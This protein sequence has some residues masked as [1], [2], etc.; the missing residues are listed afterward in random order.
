MYVHIYICTDVCNVRCGLLLLQLLCSVHSIAAR[1][2]QTIIGPP[3]DAARQHNILWLSNEQRASLLAVPLPVAS[4]QDE[5]VCKPQAHRPTLAM[6]TPS[7]LQ[8][9]SSGH[10][11]AVVSQ[12]P[13]PA[14]PGRGRAM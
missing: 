13:G 6:R 3:T 7:G 8:A 5:A 9:A 12:L 14:S 2:R 11:Q 10:S 1:A 4:H